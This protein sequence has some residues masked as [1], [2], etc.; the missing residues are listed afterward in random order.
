MEREG[1]ELVWHD[2]F[3]GKKL[4]EEWT[5]IPRFPNPPEWN[6]FMSTNDKLYKVKGGVLTL[7]EIGRA[8]CR[9]RV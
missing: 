2:E 9:E 7:Y 4:S 3:D 5:R 6:K 8:S 1:W